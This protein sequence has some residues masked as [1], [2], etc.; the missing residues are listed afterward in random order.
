MSTKGSLKETINVY[1]LIAFLYKYESF[2]VTPSNVDLLSRFSD[3]YHLGSEI[4][5]E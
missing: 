4:I 2:E 3:D 1:S 5:N